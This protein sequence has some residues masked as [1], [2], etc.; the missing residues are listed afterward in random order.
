MAK[1]TTKKPT[2]HSSFLV[3]LGETLY[4][5]GWQR[6]MAQETGFCQSTFSHVSTGKNPIS[7]ELR[8][9]LEYML[10]REWDAMSVRKTALEVALTRLRD[11]NFDSASAQASN[12]GEGGKGGE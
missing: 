10:V 1:P 2:A 8:R 4:G 6:R 3:G 12:G 9:S 7:P 11:E 5:R